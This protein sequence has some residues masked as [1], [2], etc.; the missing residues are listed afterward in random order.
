MLRTFEEPKIFFGS[1]DIGALNTTLFR[2]FAAAARA[3]I[4]S[5]YFE[6]NTLLRKFAINVVPQTIFT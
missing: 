3:R 5:S 2:F 6:G 1:S 4:I